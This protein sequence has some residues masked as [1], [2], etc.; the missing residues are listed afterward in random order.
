[1]PL[2]VVSAESDVPPGNRKLSLESSDVDTVPLSAESDRLTIKVT[3]KFVNEIDTAFTFSMPT[4][5]SSSLEPLTIFLS[6]A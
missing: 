2:T 5:S 6:L 1:M 4:N 3:S